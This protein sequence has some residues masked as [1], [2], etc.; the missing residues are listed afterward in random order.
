MTR[1]T[2]SRF[3]RRAHLWSHEQKS[4]LIESILLRIPLPMFYFDATDDNRWLVVDGLQRLSTLQ[5]FMVP[6]DPGKRL[7]RGLE[8]SNSS[9]ARP[10][11]NYPDMQLRIETGLA[12]L[13]MPGRRQNSASTSSSASTRAG[14][15]CLT[16]DPPRALR[17]RE[18]KRCDCYKNSP[19]GSGATSGSVNSERMLDMEFVPLRRVQ[20]YPYGSYRE[21]SMDDSG[22]VTWRSSTLRRRRPSVSSVST[23]WAM[24]TA[25][26]IFGA[27]TFEE[28]PRGPVEESINK[29][30]FEVVGDHRAP[31]AEACAL[32]IGVATCGSGGRKL[33][34]GVALRE[35]SPKVLATRKVLR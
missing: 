32:P 17:A 21:R 20:R 16:G 34:T 3:Q 11:S 6:E 30:L 25:L 5:H 13:I 18:W 23:R 4:R 10:S 31:F 8:Y 15:S 35:R 9:R 19:S 7:L 29:A 33:L 27:H 28:L 1:S 22:I 12:H 2:C 14:S 26:A 24:T